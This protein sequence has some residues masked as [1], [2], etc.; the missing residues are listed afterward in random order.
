MP[1]GVYKRTKTLGKNNP[2][3]KHGLRKTRFWHIWKSVKKRCLNSD[4]TT[5]HSYGGR[6]IKIC[7]E[8]LDFQNFYEDMFPDYCEAAYQLG[9]KNISIDRKNNNGHYEFENCRW[10]TRL[11][12]SNNRRNNRLLTYQGKTQTIKQWARELNINYGCLR[13]RIIYNNWTIE[14]AFNTP[15]VKPF[16]S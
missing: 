7:K 6:G 15:S 1:R 10:I 5:Y 4:D 3:Y 13:Y 11:E 12:Q 9:E 2:A 14:R 16:I 8:W